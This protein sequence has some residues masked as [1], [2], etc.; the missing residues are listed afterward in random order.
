MYYHLYEDLKLRSKGDVYIGVVGPVRTGKSTFISKF[1]DKFVLPNVTNAYDLNRCRDEMPQSADG[2]TIMTTE[3]KFIPSQSV[4]VNID[5]VEFNVRLVDCVGFMVDGALG[6]IENDQPRMVKTPWSNTKIPLI[7]AASIGTKKVINEHSTFA[8]MLTSDGSFTD[9]KRSDYKN[10]EKRTI[11]ELKKSKKPFVIVLNTANKNQ[12]EV[13]VLKEKME[14]EYKKEVLTMD[15]LNMTEEDTKNIL[16]QALNEFPIER[17]DVVFPPF[18]KALK[19]DDSIIVEITDEL[20]RALNGVEKIGQFKKDVVLFENSEHFEPIIASNINM[21]NGVVE[22]QIV[23][24]QGLFF[25]VLSTQCG[26]EIKSDYELVS[27]LKTLTDVKSK[28]DKIAAALNQVDET[29]YGV[30][31]PSMDEMELMEPE[32]VKKNGSC[33][34][35][36]KAKAPSLHIMKVDVETEVSPIMGGEKQSEDFANFLL[37]EFEENPTNIWQTNMFGKSLESLVNEGLNSK[38][39]SMPENL[40][41][42]L[43]RT[44]GKIINQGKGG[45]ICI[46]L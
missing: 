5:G 34:V 1:I 36:L 4:G 32:I 8:I 29:G 19:I 45:I 3:P 18:L 17:I 37:K 39:T 28:Y 41:L 31:V 25:E 7:E 16:M 21:S 42:K 20:M 46:L 30:V 13:K 12:Q 22:I 15:V 35:K 40:Q 38:L 43:R 44:I 6:A 24:K 27:V 2:V 10:A 9:L 23:P 33:A 11:A 14:R 26:Q